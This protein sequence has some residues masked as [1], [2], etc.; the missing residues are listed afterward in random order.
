MLEITGNDIPS[1]APGGEPAAPPR[2]PATPSPWRTRFFGTNPRLTLL[3]LAVWFGVVMLVF[4]ILLVPMIVVG[5]SMRPTYA[6][7]EVNFV[8]RWPYSA[9][10]P[11]RGDVVSIQVAPGVLY[12]KRIIGL[13]NER[14]AVRRGRLFINGRALVEPYTRSR[15]RVR[16]AD[17]T[18]GP[19]EYF[20]IGDNRPI[21]VYGVI[22]RSQIYGRAVF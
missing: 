13:P 16:A 3:R 21:T 5:N 11:Q 12:L 9:R 18:L 10:P 17:W 2:P 4:H 1:L 19:D 8:N 15:M 20:A 7:G 14:V 22:G 6:D